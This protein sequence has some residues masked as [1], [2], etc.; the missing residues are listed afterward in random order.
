MS[1][2]HSGL[3]YRLDISTFYFHEPVLFLLF[4]VLCINGLQKKLKMVL[5]YISNGLQ[6][7][8]FIEKRFFS[9]DYV[10]IN[11]L[12]VVHTWRHMQSE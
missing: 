6:K 7:N 2:I 1:M 8:L 9:V 12:R 11:E 10:K 5:W 4:Q 3:L